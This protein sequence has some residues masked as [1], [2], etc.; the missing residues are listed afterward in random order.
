[1]SKCVHKWVV[2]SYKKDKPIRQCS[3]CKKKKG[4]L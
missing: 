3:K 2:I 4:R 1:M